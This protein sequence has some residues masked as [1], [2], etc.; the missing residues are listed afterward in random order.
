MCLWFVP[1][2]LKILSA[3][4][5]AERGGYE[6]A[7]KVDTFCKALAASE[8]SL[9]VL[10]KGNSTTTGVETFGIPHPP[11]SSPRS[12]KFRIQKTAS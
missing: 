2:F 6:L 12:S 11:P 8:K 9:S 5:A 1:L 7:I 4:F 10:N 3:A